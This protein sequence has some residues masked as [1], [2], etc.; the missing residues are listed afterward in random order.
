[1]TTG[2]IARAV[3]NVL[4]SLTRLSRVL[5]PQEQILISRVSLGKLVIFLRE[6]CV[7]MC[8]IVYLLLIYIHSGVYI[9]LCHTYSHED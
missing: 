1:M 3:T 9:F 6:P 4:R 5:V 2:S 8:I 7:F